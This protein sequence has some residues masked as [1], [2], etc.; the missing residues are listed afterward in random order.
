[1]GVG[2]FLRKLRLGFVILKDAE[3]FGAFF[4]Y[5]VTAFLFLW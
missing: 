4:L 5:R 2:G 1:M 3:A